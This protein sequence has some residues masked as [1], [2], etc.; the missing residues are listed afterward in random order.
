MKQTAFLLLLV[1]PGLSFTA[2]AGDPAAGQAKS[3]VCVACHGTDGNSTNPEWPN[4]AG[5]HADYAEKQLHDFRA[6]ETRR[7]DLMAGIVAALSDEDMADLA[8][9]YATQAPAANVADPELVELGERIYRGGNLRTGV[10]AC[11]AC[12][13]PRGLGS[14]LGGFAMLAGQHPEYTAL[15]L[16]HFRSGERANDAQGMMRDSVRWMTDEEIEAVSSYIA[17]LR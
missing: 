8:A 15:Q 4:I 1:L 17:G 5:Q 9:F 14:P 13:G 16:R 6:G 3:A 7:N 11:I 12:H 10:P 2:L